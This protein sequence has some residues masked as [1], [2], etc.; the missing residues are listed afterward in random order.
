MLYNYKLSAGW[1]SRKSWD[2]LVEIR[3]LFTLVTG[4]VLPLGLEYF[5]KR[6]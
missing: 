2:Y 5:L 1:Y 3:I 6:L 4:I